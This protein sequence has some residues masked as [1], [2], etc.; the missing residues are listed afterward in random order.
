MKLPLSG[1][2]RGSFIAMRTTR[3]GNLFLSA[4]ALAGTIIFWLLL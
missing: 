3:Y 1:Q 4:I 2:F